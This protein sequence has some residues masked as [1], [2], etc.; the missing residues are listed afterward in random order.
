MTASK[1][2]SSEE[3]RHIDI[4]TAD[5]RVEPKTSLPTN[6]G[7]DMSEL[8]SPLDGKD[9]LSQD[10]NGTAAKEDVTSVNDR[11]SNVTI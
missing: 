4:E 6:K 11:A 2:K 10:D 7:D 3:P 1:A 8:Q 9:A 5:V